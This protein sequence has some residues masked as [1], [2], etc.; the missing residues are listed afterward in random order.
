ML[1]PLALTGV[2][3]LVL[4][5]HWGKGHLPPALS[6]KLSDFA[7]MVFF[8]LLLQSLWELSRRAPTSPAWRPSKRVLWVCIALTA[9]VFTLV[10]TTRAGHAVY[11]LGVAALQWPFHAAVGLLTAGRAPGLT[12]V[13]CVM[14]ATDL[15][16]LAAL[17]VPLWVGT[18]RRA[19]LR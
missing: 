4:N 14:D 10:K 6:G 2:L 1:H 11:G 19:S 7:G 13:S 16:A 17:W 9:T 3:T 5:D 12:P 18:S 8:P 15:V